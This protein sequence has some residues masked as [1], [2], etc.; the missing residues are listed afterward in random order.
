MCS[1]F[2]DDCLTSRSPRRQG[3]TTAPVHDATAGSLWNGRT[4]WQL[5]EEAAGAHATLVAVD[6]GAA[7]VTYADLRARADRVA[8]AV[9]GECSGHGRHVALLAEPSADAVAAMLGTMKAGHAYVPL[10]AGDPAERL[11][12]LLDDS[13]AEVLLVDRANLERAAALGGP[14]RQVLSLDALPCQPG[15][16]GPAPSDADAIAYLSYTSGST[17]QPKGVLQTHRARVHATWH[18][19]RFHGIGPGDRNALLFS[20]SFSASSV[21]LY[22]ALLNGATLCLPHLQRRGVAALASWLDNERITMAHSVPSVWRTLLSQP[23]PVGGLRSLRTF[24]LGGESVFAHEIAAWRARF[25]T[26]TRLTTRL[27]A[28]EVSLITESEIGDVTGVSGPIPVG[29]AAPGVHLAIVRD[30]GQAADAGEPGEIIVHTP[31]ASPG[32]WRQPELTASRFSEDP[33]RRGWR[34]YRGGDRGRLDEHGHITVLGRADAV[35]RVR[36]YSVH[37][38]EVEAALRRVD[39]VTQAAVIAVG[40]D[41]DPTASTRLVAFVTG[42]DAAGVRAALTS[43]LPGYAVPSEV[44]RAEALPMTASGKLDA[45][46]LTRTYRTLASRRA[47]SVPGLIGHERAVAEL[48]ARILAL[49]DVGRDADFF[50][51]G[52]DSM[53]LAALH[54]E[55]ERLAGRA[56]VPSDLFAAPTVAGFARLLAAPASTATSVS[57]LLAA[58]RIGGVSRPLFLVHG[59]SGRVVGSRGFLDAL[60][61]DQPVWGFRAPTR[62]EHHP[63]L[64]T[65]AGMASAYVE[66]MRGVQ[67]HGPYYL[68]GLCAGNIVATEMACQLRD[69]GERVAPLLLIDPPPLPSDQGGVSFLVK[70]TLLRLGGLLPSSRVTEVVGG[71]THRLG[72]VGPRRLGRDG[73]DV[74]VRF[75]VATYAHRARSYDGPAHLVTSRQRRARA[76]AS[77]R[78]VLIGDVQVLDAGRSH[79]EVFTSSNGEAARVVRACV[80]QVG[81]WMSNAGLG[82]QTRVVS[83]NEPPS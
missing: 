9:A 67:P 65:I 64:R 27:A 1:L 49:P 69:A 7:S 23:V 29:R 66:A 18:Y 34:I 12:T 60:G 47:A 32:Y 44:H 58:I 36:G 16:L 73:F 26:H 79:H 19:G 83:G 20:L 38:A 72:F 81:A 51:L 14:R 8:A 55:L 77:W 5:F 46:A 42:A 53:T 40:T 13:D 39:G 74:W 61:P 10:D 4:I 30:D 80:D 3:G 76:W 17:G 11:R 78:R 75:R 6:D 56:I 48:V 59:G 82:E 63:P 22:G 45:A 52:G 33:V 35:V 62:A 2:P 25:G 50:E 31:Y 28:T 43:V 71:L 37:L 68:G 70:G 15:A 54:L 24:D 41:G 57:P 21:V